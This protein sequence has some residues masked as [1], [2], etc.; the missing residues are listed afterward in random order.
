MYFVG[1]SILDSAQKGL[2]NQLI[3]FMING[4]QTYLFIQADMFQ[5]N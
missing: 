1:K 4:A 5:L 3:I 2:Q